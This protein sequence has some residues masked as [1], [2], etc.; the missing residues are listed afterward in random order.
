MGRYYTI[1]NVDKREELSRPGGLKM[2]EWCYHGTFK[3]QAL[4]NLLAG[5]WKGDRVFVL[6][7]RANT[8]DEPYGK[9]LAEVLRETGAEN[10]RLYVD[11]HYRQVDPDEVDAED[12]GYRYIYNH[13]LKV[14]LD[15]EHCPFAR[16]DI[17]P[18]PLLLAMGFLGAGDGGDFD[19][20]TTEMEEMVGSWCDS[21]RSLEVRKEPLP[22][23]DYAEF[24]PDFTATEPGR[25]YLVVNVDKREQFHSEDSKL[26]N[27]AYT[28]AGMVTYLL[29]LLAGPWKGD[30]VYVVAH[31]ARSGWEF[32]ENDDL[33]DTLAQSE[34][35][36][37]FAYAAAH[38]KIPGGE[39]E[40]IQETGEAIRYIYNHALKVCIDITH[41]PQLKD[42]W[43]ST[44][45]LPLLLA[46]GH[47][48][49][50]KGDFEAG[51]NGFAHVGTWCATARSIEVSKEPLPGVDYPEFRPDFMEKEYMD[52]WLR[53]RKETA[54]S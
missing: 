51:N 30:R 7:N 15:L 48:G 42:H 31:D 2:A 9:A 13:A 38:F 11:E 12:H 18:L 19:L 40:D 43:T 26:M 22:G 49:D 10:L 8:E 6:T 44:A 1:V 4:L 35:K 52:E 24:R 25:F 32:P 16:D 3:V 23:V 50:M 34:E 41:C 33:C 47:H 45:P 5:R 53:E 27:W 54:A 20:I 21:V 37:L 17:A 46:L 36:T 14:F 29:G 39:T 28:K